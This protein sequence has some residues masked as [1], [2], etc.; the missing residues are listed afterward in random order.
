MPSI[1]QIIFLVYVREIGILRRS[2]SLFSPYDFTA[3]GLM[4]TFVKNLI[5]I[6]PI[7]PQLESGTNKA[8][9]KVNQEYAKGALTSLRKK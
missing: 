9:F 6:S 8:Q 5:V 2:E 4:T 3:R 7:Q 1:L